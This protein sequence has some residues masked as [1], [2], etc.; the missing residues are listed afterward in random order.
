MT[1]FQHQFNQAEYVE[2]AEKLAGVGVKY[3]KEADND[4]PNLPMTYKN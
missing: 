4:V 2:H 1:V 3:G